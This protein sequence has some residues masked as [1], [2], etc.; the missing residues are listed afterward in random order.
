MKKTLLIFL[1]V[2][3][4]GV[5]LFL[6]TPEASASGSQNAGK[7]TYTSDK[8][9]FIHFDSEGTIIESNLPKNENQNKR[10]TLNYSTGRWVYF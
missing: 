10:A 5:L 8:E 2:V 4:L 9:G 7:V 1:S 6:P 3:F